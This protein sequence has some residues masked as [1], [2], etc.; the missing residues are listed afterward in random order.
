MDQLVTLE[1]LSATEGFGAERALKPAPNPTGLRSH[2]T[3]DS[4]M[5][6]AEGAVEEGCMGRKFVSKRIGQWA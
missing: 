6:T 4:S 2:C 5:S 1:V 3:S